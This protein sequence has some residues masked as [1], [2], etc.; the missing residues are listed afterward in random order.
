MYSFRLSSA[1]DRE[2][3]SGHGDKGHTSEAQRPRGSEARLNRKTSSGLRSR[4]SG[5]RYGLS[6]SGTGAGPEPAPGAE[7]LNLIPE[8]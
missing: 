5:I 6:G 4:Q 7:H 8:G 3:T 1:E 2:G